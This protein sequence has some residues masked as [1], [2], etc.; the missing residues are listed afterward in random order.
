MGMTI[1]VPFPYLLKGTHTAA[2]SCPRVAKRLFFYTFVPR[3]PS[4]ESRAIH[5]ME[6]RTCVQ[7]VLQ[8]QTPH[9]FEEGVH[10]KIMFPEFMMMIA[11]IITLGEIM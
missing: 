2:P 3:T 11:F 5:L 4:L 6:K 8:L 9:E 10:I 1:P 7:S